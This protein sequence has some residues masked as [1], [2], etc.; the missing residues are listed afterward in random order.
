MD[1]IGQIGS[2]TPSIRVVLPAA[3]LERL[4]AAAAREQRSRSGMARKLLAD[5]LAARGAGMTTG[6]NDGGH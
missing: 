4:D 1:E 2:R 5:A 6:G 3:T